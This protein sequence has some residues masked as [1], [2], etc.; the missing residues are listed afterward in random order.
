MKK[1]TNIS[2]IFSALVS[3]LVSALV[4]TIFNTLVSAI[5]SALKICAVIFFW[6][7]E[8]YDYLCSV[9]DKGIRCESGTVPAAVSSIQGKRNKSLPQ[10]EKTRL[11][12]NKS[13]DLP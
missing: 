9:L 4:S 8:I 1:Q 2:R 6:T 13:E 5:F 3:T 7:L 12:R 11:C 10:G